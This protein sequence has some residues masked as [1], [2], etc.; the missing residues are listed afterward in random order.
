MEFDYVEITDLDDPLG[1]LR[2][3][4]GGPMATPILVIDDEHLI[5]FDPAWIEARLPA[6][7][8]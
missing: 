4:T 3:I 1:T 8:S 2:T 6:T 5:G 7:E